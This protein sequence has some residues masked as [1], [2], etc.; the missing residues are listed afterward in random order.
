MMTATMMIN[1]IV[2]DIDKTKDEERTP[3]LFYI[4]RL[5]PSMHE[6]DVPMEPPNHSSHKVEIP[7]SNSIAHSN[8]SRVS[9][10]ESTHAHSCHQV[11]TT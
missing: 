2:Y 5:E 6:Q 4:V 7:H 3:R 10:L 1:K 11:L 9:D 8:W